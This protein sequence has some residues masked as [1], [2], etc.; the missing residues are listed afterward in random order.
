MFLPITVPGFITQPQPTSGNDNRDGA[1]RDAYVLA[2]ANDTGISVSADGNQENNDFT[3]NADKAK[4]QTISVSDSTLLSQE[5]QEVAQTGTPLQTARNP[6]KPAEFSPLAPVQNM[7][8]FKQKQETPTEPTR[9]ANT[10][11][12]VASAQLPAG[13]MQNLFF[14][15]KD[16]KQKAAALNQQKDD[17]AKNREMLNMLPMPTVNKAKANA[18]ITVR[19]NINAGNTIG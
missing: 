17:V 19:G 2:N 11:N 8:V 5:E 14:S 9:E 7:N 18:N 6:D 13:Q 1:T 12:L 10:L 15:V 16:F 4:N 3:V